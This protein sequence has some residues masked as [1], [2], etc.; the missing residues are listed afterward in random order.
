MMNI[1][2]KLALF[3]DRAV[4]IGQ[5]SGLTRKGSE[6]ALLWL[7]ESLVN[8]DRMEIRNNRLPPLYRAGVR[9]VREPRGS[10]NWQDASTLVRA[11][12]GDC[13]DLAC[14]RT[15]E[16]RNNGKKADPYIRW[17]RD[18]ATGMYIYHVLVKRP[19]GL[20]DPSLKLGMR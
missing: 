3:A 20:E 15:A 5:G 17:R 4:R 14:Y 10:E 16:L 8:I 1:T 7:L 12:E 19:G 2:F 18:S 9:Y 6:K 11:G 13:E